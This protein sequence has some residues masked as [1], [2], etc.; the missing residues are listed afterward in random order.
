LVDTDL[1]VTLLLLGVPLT[2]ED[3]LIASCWGCALETSGNTA[4]VVVPLA[5]SGG[6]ALDGGGPLTALGDTSLLVDPLT[7]IELGAGGGTGLTLA[8]GDTS[9]GN[10]FAANGGTASSC[11]LSCS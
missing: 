10:P 11:A 2:L 5:F 1:N 4:L 6:F 9:V 3:V 8:S 7:F